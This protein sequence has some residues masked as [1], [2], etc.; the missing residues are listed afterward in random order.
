MELHFIIT[1]FAYLHHAVTIL[2]QLAEEHAKKDDK[3]CTHHAV[4]ASDWLPLADGLTNRLTSSKE[5]IWNHETQM[6]L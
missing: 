5:F 2:Q 1:E 3:G 4:T 6:N